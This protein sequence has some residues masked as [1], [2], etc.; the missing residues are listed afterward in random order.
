MSIHKSWLEP[1]TIWHHKTIMQAWDKLSD[2]TK[3]I[4][5]KGTPWTKK[6]IPYGDYQA[7]TNT[8]SNDDTPNES[9]QR[10][11]NFFR[12]NFKPPPHAMY[13]RREYDS[14]GGK[15]RPTKRKSRMSRKSKNKK[16]KRTRRARR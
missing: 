3:D 16:R 4:L 13:S 5:S 14:D 11:A 7:L 9:E 8:S 10:T 15:K 2:K 12:S 1:D 6:E